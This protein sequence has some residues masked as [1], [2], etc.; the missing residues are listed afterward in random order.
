MKDNTQNEPPRLRSR[1]A[2]NF[3]GALTRAFA[4]IASASFLLV[5]PVATAKDHTS[6]KDKGMKILKKTDPS[7]V[8]GPDNLFTGTARIESIITEPDSPSQ[9]TAARVTFE[10][11]ARTN[12]HQHPLGQMLIVTDG[13]GWTQVEGA[14]KVEFQAGDVMTCPKNKRHWHGATPDSSMTHIAVQE[15][16][17]GKNVEWF[18]PV[19]DEV[20]LDE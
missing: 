6:S 7:T 18:E 14:E 10:P 4:I 20:Y 8:N 9:I 1:I 17:E 5:G 16:Y 12:W 13:V 19:P 15:M 3:G 2:P 11:G